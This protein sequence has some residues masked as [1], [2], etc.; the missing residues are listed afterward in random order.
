M[1]GRNPPHMVFELLYYFL[2][3][4]S[5][6]NGLKWKLPSLSTCRVFEHHPKFHSFDVRWR[7]SS[8]L[9]PQKFANF[10]YYNFWKITFLICIDN[11]YI[12]WKLKTFYIQI[13]HQKI[14]FVMKQFAWYEFLKKF[15]LIFHGIFV[16]KSKFSKHF[17]TQPLT[18]VLSTCFKHLK[19]NLHC[20]LTLITALNS[21]WQAVEWAWGGIRPIMGQLGLISSDEIW[22]VFDSK[23]FK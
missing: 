17:H 9:W 8:L 7:K 4:K 20:I 3:W 18:F 5:F 19:R 22:I 10:W 12:K 23:E 11:M 14:K 1:V 6:I 15:C 13:W 21:K 2:S 16:Q